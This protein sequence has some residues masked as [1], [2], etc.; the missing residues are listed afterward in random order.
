MVVAG[1]LTENSWPTSIIPFLAGA[2]LMYFSCANWSERHDGS[3]PSTE[4]FLWFEHVPFIHATESPF[5]P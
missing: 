3:A 4:C 5:M 2:F 1:N